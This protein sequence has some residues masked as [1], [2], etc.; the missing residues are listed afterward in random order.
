MSNRR[1]FL[2][3]LG[4]G[5]M[6]PLS[7]LPAL[8]QQLTPPES[9]WEKI[10]K[11]F[12]IATDHHYFNN[13]T[14]GISPKPVLE[15]LKKRLEHTDS[16]GDYGQIEKALAPLARLVKVKETE[17]S[18]MHNVTEGINTVAMGLPLRR[19]DEVLITDQEHV[20]GATPWL[21]RMSKGECTV[22]VFRLGMTDEETLFNLE[23][24]I[25]KRTKVLAIPHLTCTNGY[26][27][28][29]KEIVSIAR[30]KNIWVVVDGAHPPG[31]L[32]INLT[33]LGID[34]YASCCHKWMLGPK[35]T[36]FL[37][38]NEQFRDIVKPTFA[39]AGVDLKWD[40]LTN[41]P[42]Y[43][44]FAPNGHRYYYGTQNAALF[45]TIEDTVNYIEAIGQK[46]IE[47]RIRS[48]ATYFRQEI[49]AMGNR[50][51]I[52]TPA[53]EQ[54]R[55]GVIT[56]RLK[57][58]PFDKVSKLANEQNYRIRNVT[59]H[60]INANRV[61]FHIYNSLEEIQEFVEF[62]YDIA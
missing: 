58:N 23:K 42:M 28:P 39:G 43:Q 57:N 45:D 18:F 62:L 50:A 2:K 5:A 48:F 35:G 61:S 60:G 49:E 51:D 46:K 34:T 27:L 25:T 59:E 36:G 26:L 55:G 33:E 16:T 19:K 29:L 24:S 52:L 8:E 41:P 17:L 4:I 3:L 1:N 6:T 32:D 47:T 13:G 20:G 44:G 37:Y 56:F 30:Q 21:Y 12:L 10:R 22:K 7:A 40:I 31:M 14:M 53:A 54:S 15:A 38:V 9:F 11:D